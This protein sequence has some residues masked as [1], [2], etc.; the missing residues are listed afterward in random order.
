MSTALRQMLVWGLC[1]VKFTSNQPPLGVDN[2]RHL[3]QPSAM[4]ATLLNLKY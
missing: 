2:E 3:E 4:Q 1:T